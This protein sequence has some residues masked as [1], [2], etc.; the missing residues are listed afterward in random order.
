MNSSPVF[1][2]VNQ[3]LT[4]VVGRLLPGALAT[5]TF[6]SHHPSAFCI[7]FVL[8][9]FISLFVIVKPSSGQGFQQKEI[10]YR[11]SYQAQNTPFGVSKYYLWGMPQALL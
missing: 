11:L 7:C 9:K 3:G 1:F 4:R 10:L 6:A 5:K 2:V 8:G